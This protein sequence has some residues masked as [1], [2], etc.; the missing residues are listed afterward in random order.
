MLVC[1][2]REAASTFC[3]TAARI[4][5][6]LNSGPQRSLS[7]SVGLCA[8]GRSEEQPIREDNR[9]PLLVIARQR[10]VSNLASD[11]V[12]RIVFTAAFPHID[13]FGVWLGTT[14]DEEREAL[15][16]DNPRYGQ[17][18]QVL[19]DG[20]FTTEQ[21]ADL[22]RTAQSQET[23]DRDYEGSRFYALR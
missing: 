2:M 1:E 13:G 5:A 12:V 8:D 4:E 9:W 20:G 19:I 14:T 6:L 11:G 23:V 7:C 3:A 22:V 10:L 15:G 18:R 16:G 21:L 17:V